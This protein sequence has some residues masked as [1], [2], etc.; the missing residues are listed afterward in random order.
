MQR[1][2]ATYCSSHIP[3]CTSSITI[4]FF[5]FDDYGLSADTC[6]NTKRCTCPQATAFLTPT[7]TCIMP[8]TY[9]YLSFVSN[10]ILV[11]P[12]AVGKTS[13]QTFLAQSLVLPPPL[14]PQPN[15]VSATLPSLQNHVHNHIHHFWSVMW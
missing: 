13:R 12:V 11:K 2:R 5:V 6:F 14:P 10:M 15:I 9:A 8:S 1:L 4:C 3:T 7:H